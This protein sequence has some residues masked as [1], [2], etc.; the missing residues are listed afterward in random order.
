MRISTLPQN[1]HTWIV[2][3]ASNTHLTL[4]IERFIRYT[5]LRKPQIIKGNGEPTVCALGTGTVELAN[6]FGVNNVF[7]VPEALDS[8]LSMQ[9]LRINRHQIDFGDIPEATYSVN[10]GHRKC[11]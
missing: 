11:I 2:D 1:Y 8:I 6:A 5:R 3:S 7:Y 9:K 10:W 4:Y